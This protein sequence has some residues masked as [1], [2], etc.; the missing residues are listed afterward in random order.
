MSALKIYLDQNVYSHLLDTGSWQQ[1]PITQILIAARDKRIAEVWISPTNVMETSQASDPS[2]KRELASMMLQLSSAKRMILSSDFLVIEQLA[3]FLNGIVPNSF[4]SEPYFSY[5]KKQAQLIWLGNLALLATG[6]SEPGPATNMILRMKLESQVIHARLLADPDNT[7]KM[8]I[9]GVRSH[10]TTHEIDP[11]GLTKLTDD[12]IKQEISSLSFK[13][14]P[15]SDTTMRFLQRNRAEICTAYG[16][17]DIGGAIHGIFKLPF[18]LELTFDTPAII[19]SWSKFQQNFQVPPLP[20]D[21]VKLSPLE[22]RTDRD[23]AI[24]VLNSVIRA[25]ANA[26]LPTISVGYYSLMR[27]LEICMNQG[28]LPTIGAVLD[29]DHSTSAVYFDVIVCQDVALA[30]NLKS[31]V[32]QLPCE[33][34]IISNAHQLAKLLRKAG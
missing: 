4:R 16:A 23:V 33:I 22:Q 10:A 5:Y 17:V 3:A 13:M 15:P 25:V 7:I 11:L 26:Y 18:D 6:F 1:Q 14:R 24:M 34:H 30:E 27:E 31:F 12:Q 28:R 19:A 9:D 8:I 20:E 21:I 2:R 32:K 29:V